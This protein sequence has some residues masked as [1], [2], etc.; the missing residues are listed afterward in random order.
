MVEFN[1][2]MSEYWSFRSVTDLSLSWLWE[3]FIGDEIVKVVGD[4]ASASCVTCSFGDVGD[5]VT[6]GINSSEDSIGS[7]RAVKFHF[8][9][10]YGIY[11]W[12]PW[13]TAIL[14]ILVIAI[15]PP[16]FP[17]PFISPTIWSRSWSRWTLST[18]PMILSG[19]AAFRMRAAFTSTSEIEGFSVGHISSGTEWRN[20]MEKSDSS[21]VSPP[22]RVYLIIDVTAPSPFT[23]RLHT[24]R[25]F[26][27]RWHNLESLSTTCDSPL[28]S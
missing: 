25:T 3:W 15:I 26:T 10:A 2:S 20:Y 22:S 8:F 28:S 23:P 11:P 12:L 24:W 5:C 13:S 27:T 17:F 7:Q 1:F 18:F 14:V 19:V 6:H 16:W 9:K 4:V 21:L